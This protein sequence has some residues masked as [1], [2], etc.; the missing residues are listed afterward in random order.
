MKFSKNRLIFFEEFKTCLGKFAQ[1]KEKKIGFN[2]SI[3]MNKSLRKAIMLISQVKRKFKNNKSEE[4]SKK[5][6]QE[7]NY[8][9]KLLRKT[10]MEY[11]QNMDVNKINDNKIFWKTVKPRFSNKCKTA[12]TIILTEADIAKTLKLKK[13]PNF[14]GQSLFSIIGYFKNNESVIKIKE[15]CNAQENSFSFSL[16]SKEDILKAIKSLSSNKAFPT[17]DIPTEISKTSI[18]IYSEKLPNIFNESL[19]NGRFPD[20]YSDFYK[21]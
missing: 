3:F 2:N 20:T 14:D 8:C 5:Y 7:R 21:R 9:I 19:I 10:K 6:K 15:K 16:F 4:N 1:L 12:N 11:F 13:H 18:H 17:E